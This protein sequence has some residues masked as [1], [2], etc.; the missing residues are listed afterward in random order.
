MTLLSD[1]WAVAVML[2]NSSAIDV[3]FQAKP[4]GNDGALQR[5]ALSSKYLPGATRNR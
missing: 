2:S 1:L 4:N 5:K 3:P